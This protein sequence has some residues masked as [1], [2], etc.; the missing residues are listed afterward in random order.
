MTA[1]STEKSTK[2]K[3]SPTKVWD[4]KYGR[5]RVKQAPPTLEEAIFAAKGITDDLKSQVEIAA[6]LMGMTPDEV[7]PQ[8]MKSSHT[9]FRQV[10]GN[11]RDPG[12][13]RTF[14]V[15]KRVVRRVAVPSRFGS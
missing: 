15:E 9:T 5:R 13:A 12:S 1:T 3:A 7:R 10:A 8:V 14:V 4:T 6:E 2:S 11:A